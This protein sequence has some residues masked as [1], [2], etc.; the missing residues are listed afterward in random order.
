MER[1]TGPEK[2]LK[3]MSQGPY[4]GLTISVDSGQLSAPH[5]KRRLLGDCIRVRNNLESGKWTKYFLIQAD[6][7][8]PSTQAHLAHFLILFCHEHTAGKW[9]IGVCE[10][11]QLP[12]PS[13]TPARGSFMVP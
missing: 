8:R 11:F 7:P 1:A 2:Q 5:L 4:E 9:G 13:Q 12:E 6:L 10:K 3:A